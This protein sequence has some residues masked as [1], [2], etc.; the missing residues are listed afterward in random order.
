MCSKGKNIMNIDLVTVDY[1]DP[2]QAE[3]LVYLLDSYAQDSMG[4]GEPLAQTT[5]ENLAMSLSKVPNAF[6]V[7]CYVD[8]QAAGLI[9]CFEAFSTFKCKPLVNIH[10]VAVLSEFRGLGISQKMLMKVEQIANEKGCCKLTLE[11]LEGNKVAKNA[12]VK[13][14]FAGYE[15]DPKMGQA[16]FW[17]KEL[18]CISP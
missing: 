15:L 7:I 3:D 8:G 14:G 10:D 2:Q 16:Q 4:G 6:S 11:V 1:D 13:F 12:Y 17:E 5:K 18:Q 9:N